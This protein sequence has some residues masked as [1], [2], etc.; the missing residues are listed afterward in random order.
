MLQLTPTEQITIHFNS[1]VLK[2]LKHAKVLKNMPTV[3]KI[4]FTKK[5]IVLLDLLVPLVKK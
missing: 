3:L 2:I 5:K 4:I 1:N